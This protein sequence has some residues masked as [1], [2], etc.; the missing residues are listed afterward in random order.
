LIR[1][2]DMLFRWG[3]DEFLV[4]MFNLSEIEV[5]KRIATL[6][7]ILVQ[8]CEHWTGLPIK[9]TV[10]YGVAGFSSM[11]GLAC[12]IETADQAM[13]AQRQKMRGATKFQNPS[14]LPLTS[15]VLVDVH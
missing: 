5:S 13:Y 2:D 15:T 8:N 7:E 9:V 6:N 11:K 14:I 1:A 4:L 12:G 10:S 3:G